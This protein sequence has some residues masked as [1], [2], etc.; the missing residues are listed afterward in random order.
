MEE[1]L[2]G[3][4]VTVGNRAHGTEP[5][6]DVLSLVGNVD[7][8]PI[9]RT[10]QVKA[11]PTNLAA[12][13]SRAL[14]KFVA[15]ESGDYDQELLNRLVYMHDVRLLPTAVRPADL[16]YKLR[17]YRITVLHQEDRMSLTLLTRYERRLPGPVGRRSLRLVRIEAWEPMWAKL[18]ATV[19]AHLT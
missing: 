6:F 7:K 1:A 13:C 5:A 3:A 14:G 18:A 15:L 16:L 19:Y 2:D 17:H 9:L 8:D 12:N 10:V 4:A 11:T